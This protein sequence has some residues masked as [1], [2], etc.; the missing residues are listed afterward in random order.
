V[1]SLLLRRGEERLDP[2]HV[3]DRPGG[4][5]AVL[6]QRGGHRGLRVMA[7]LQAII[8]SSSGMR[9]LLLPVA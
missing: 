1:N 4:A 3:A 8:S 5:G 6:P 2:A 9:S 7:A